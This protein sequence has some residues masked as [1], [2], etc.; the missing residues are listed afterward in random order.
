MRPQFDPS[1]LLAE[2]EDDLLV[3][4]ITQMLLDT[5]PGLLRTIEEAVAAG[6]AAALKAGAH[7]LRGSVA[8]FGL[9][10]ATQATLDLERLAANGQMASAPAVV[11]GLTRDVGILCAGARSWLATRAAAAS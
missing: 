5:A 9:D 8:T 10:S 4:E 7:R 1:R 11:A 6:D 3:A 2:Y